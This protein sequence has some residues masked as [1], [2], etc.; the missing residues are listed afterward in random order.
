MTENQSYVALILPDYEIPLTGAIA[1]SLIER[2]YF[3]ITIGTMVDLPV[4][5][6]VNILLCD[7]NGIDHH[8][9]GTI[10]DVMSTDNIGS[11]IT[12]IEEHLVQTQ[13]LRQRTSINWVIDYSYHDL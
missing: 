6:D 12:K 9:I 13:P 7:S 5:L 8:N 1:I 11:I 4:T 10:V 3:S 2:S